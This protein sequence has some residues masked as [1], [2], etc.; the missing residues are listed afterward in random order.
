MNGTDRIRRAVA[1]LGDGPLDAA[2][3]REHIFPLFS[4]T[5]EAQQG[6][7]V[8][9]NHS[10]GR[11]LDAL[12]E[13]VREGL[14][15][16]YAQQGGAWDHWMDEQQAF[17]SRLGELCGVDAQSI[18]FKTSAGAG[19][20]AVL[21]TWD[22][23]VNVVAT[24]GEFD[25]LDVIL[26][27]YAVR[28]RIKL[29][30]VEPDGEGFFDAGRIADAIV[31]G[32]DLVVVSQV[33][34]QTGQRLDVSLIVEAAR[35]HRA[36]VL[37]DVY[38][39]LGV[40]AVD[41]AALGVDFAV[42][43]SYKYLRGGPGAAFLYVS[44]EQ[45]RVRRPLDIGWF[46]KDAPQDYARPDSPRFAAG[47]DGWQESTPPVLA[48]YQARSGQVFTLAMGVPRLR[49][50]SLA[51]QR[52]LVEALASL[53]IE[54]RGGTDDRGAFVVVV[55]P[56]A[57]AVAAKLEERGVLADA[58]GAWLRLCPD[59]LTSVEAIDEAAGALAAALHRVQAR[60]GTPAVSP[61]T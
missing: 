19:L 30:L 29:S 25:S 13:D 55:H 61:A 27:E 42:G 24:R 52:R 26:R 58:R 33:M 2:G 41:L 60:R 12:E 5:L 9:S 50:W 45:L 7:I 11:P 48:W 22:A 28:G 21:G 32:T 4:R 18:V 49:A 16:W 20:R 36:H 31:P 15:A 3:L 10:L 14:A 23:P 39:S 40:F 8:L 46:A 56:A 37:L 43:G 38:H 57:R 54:A 17:R 34:F 47:G 59:I 53:D 51:L 6:R 44:T 35:R 1:A